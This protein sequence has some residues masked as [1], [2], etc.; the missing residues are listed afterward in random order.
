MSFNVRRWRR[1][2]PLRPASRLLRLEPLESRALLAAQPIITEFAASNS[3][4]LVDGDGNFSDWIE[5]FNAGDRSLDLDPWHLTDDPANLTRWSFPAPTLLDPG[6]YLVVFASGQLTP[7]YVDAG[8]NPHANFRLDAGG[9]FVALVA[10]DGVTIASQFSADGSDYPPQREDISYGVVQT[11]DQTTLVAVGAAGKLLVPDSA[12][13]AQI[14]QS[15]T[16]GSEPFADGAWLDV[17][18]GVG[19]DESPPPTNTA[20][21]LKI[22][23]GDSTNAGGGPGGTQSGFQPFEHTGTSLVTKPYAT[24]MGVAGTV[25]V[26]VFGNTH[27]RDYAAATGIFASQSALL[28][29]GLLCN[30]SCTVSLT[31]DGLVDGDYRLTTYHHT[32][33]FGPSARPPA[34]PFDVY[35]S[36][37]D[38]ANR[39]VV[40]GAIMS[41]NASAALVS[42]TFDF[43]NRGGASAIVDFVRGPS[44]G[45]TD[46]HFALPGFMLELLPQPAVGE[47][48]A[49]DVAAAMHGVNASSYLRIPFSVPADANYDFL[50]LDVQYDDGFVAYLDGVEIARR[51]APG[52]VGAAPAFDAASTSENPPGNPAISERIDVT[53]FLGQLT[54]GATAVLAFHGLNTSA[55]DDDFLI[56]PALTATRVT[57]GEPRYLEPPTPGE[58]NGD[59]FV[60]FVADTRF[61]VDRGVFDTAA[62]AFDVEITSATTGATIVY[63]LDASAPTV[64]A[65]GNVLNGAIYSGP[66]HVDRTTTLRAMAFAL[67]Q[68]ASNVDTQTYLFLDD[69]LDQ[70]STPPPGYPA[71]WGG[72]FTEWGLD[73]NADDLKL[74]AGDAGLTLDEARQVI[75]GSLR[76]LPT[77]SLVLDVDD[78]FGAASG[79]YANSQADGKAWERAASVELFDPGD[80]GIGF[81]IDAG[82]RIQGFTSRDPNRN[83]KHSLRLVF[84]KEY[85]AAKLN[86]PFFGDDAAQEFDTIVLRSNSQDAWVYNT[87]YNRQG[88][89]I[90]DQWA[91]ATQLAMGHASPHGEWVHLYINGL[92]WGV[93]NPTERPDASFDASYFGGDK[94]DYDSLK[95][96]EEVVD[97]TIDAYRQLLALIQ[98]DPNNFGAGYRD[99]SSAADYQ[100]LQGNNPDGTRNP[101]FPVLLDVP[102]LIDYMIHNMYA[103]AQDWPGNF[104]IGR[105]RTENSEGFHFFDWD[106]EHGMKQSVT[107]NR[108]VA[109]SR[110]ADSPTKFHQAL[111]SNADYRLL[112]ADHVHRAFSPGGVLYVDPQNPAWDPAHPERNVP[113]ARWMELSGEIEQALI[114]EAARWGDVRGI[115]YTSHDQFQAVRND[116]LLN[117]FPQRSQIVLNQFKAQGLY[118]D[119]AA[120]TFSQDG[121][122]IVPGFELGMSAPLSNLIVD[123]SLVAP[124]HTASVL[125][126][127]SS[128][129][130]LIG[131]SWIQPG[132]VPGAAGETAWTAGATGVGYE[133]SPLDAINFAALLGTDITANLA[134]VPNQTSVYARM[135]FGVNAEFDPADY[136]RLLLN[137]KFDDGFVAYLNGV[138]VARAFA[139]AVVAWNSASQGGNGDVNAV[140]YQPFDITQ[141]LSLLQPGTNVL[142][143]HGLN[144]TATSSDMLVLPELLL[145]QQVTATD[146]PIY[147]TLDGSDPRLPGGAINP[148]AMLY[149]GPVPIPA[150]TQVRARSLVGGV[151]SALSES[152]FT[153]VSP[154]RITELMYHPRE[155]S[156]PETFAD[157]DE[158]EFIEIQNVGATAT[159]D[160]A[161][162]RFAAGVSFT[163][164]SVLLGPGQFAV[165][166]SNPIA[167][168]QR[169]GDTVAVVGQYAGKLNNGGE[170]LVL[171]GPLGETIQSFAFDDDWLPETD[172]DGFSLVAVDT[173]GE[174]DDPIN[175]RSSARLDGSPV[176]LD[177]I[178]V[179]GDLNG[180]GLVSR[181]DAAVLA[182]GFG[183]AGGS[184]R[185]RGDVDGDGRTSLAD[186][187]LLQNYLGAVAA[188]S[189]AMAVA[190]R[191]RAPQ[192]LVV[193][194]AKAHSLGRSDVDASFREVDSMR[195]DDVSL[196]AR[197]NHRRIRLFAI[198]PRRTT[199]V[200]ADEIA[201]VR[202][203]RSQ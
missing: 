159:V 129:N 172:G 2:L 12:T 121:G 124:G 122:E 45:G 23:F 111:L 52:V 134:T 173:G 176:L 184:Y 150:T 102:N 185:T 128:D 108:V 123:T 5:I 64:T 114:A 38:G 68:R 90:R 56:R 25:N 182:G 203:L 99:I 66:I 174:Y 198:H 179:L 78:V 190:Q 29:D 3:R 171:L 145:G 59:G 154:L 50:S 177:P 181:L 161:E 58:H 62:D 22:D 166:A 139:P 110:D 31:F 51:S 71:T 75:K 85:G 43:T 175:W 17:T 112:F 200:A 87:E 138:E 196:Y 48:V 4:T 186:A 54:P 195:L 153:V 148:I 24:G 69:V 27:W 60:G 183:L 147:F 21:P 178:P 26:S 34:T 32:T 152:L 28:A 189:P 95:N 65:A 105:D 74:I 146:A 126:P 96:H 89:F 61:S 160:L 158:Y 83:P 103:A 57:V 120:P 143:I 169:Y 82:L 104:Y 7:D 132:F 76:S 46:D 94:D 84:R 19:F 119:L 33:Q 98:N 156:G 73:Q 164:P 201:L 55:A 149:G 16:G 36:D 41:D 15:W 30:A 188:S 144:G 81:Q 44:N 133:A 6:E 191:A 63:T 135:T 97:G 162:Y 180:D 141:H 125:V 11:I 199:Q 187:A 130:S 18:T 93:Y 20:P 168:A 155:A 35:V 47:L 151:W 167:F 106:N 79:I 91:R 116:L 14:G 165:I 194:A 117:W 49:T 142:A 80:A 100:Q 1:A 170:S 10:P 101:A 137:M 86:Y 157:R 136:D 88:Q 39:T 115:Q 37:A 118:P 40:T 70:G 163:F 72:T 202:R 67:D 197:E 13:D 92:Y 107:E 77:L 42:Q 192:A 193:R 127:S 113:A 131:A 8:G 109:H 140:V 9:E 53:P